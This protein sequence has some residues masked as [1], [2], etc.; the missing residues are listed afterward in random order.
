M[1]LESD[2]KMA[3][4]IAAHASWAATPDR[5]A[6]TAA[7]R[8]G[9]V[10]KFEREVDPDGTLP[11]AERARRAESLRKAHYVRLALAS[12]KSRRHAAGLIET[13][14]AAEGELAELGGPDAA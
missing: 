2:R 9:L 1:S 5:T 14:K 13:A 8:A 4:Q 7:A 12:A 11:L 3:A 10:A 6:R